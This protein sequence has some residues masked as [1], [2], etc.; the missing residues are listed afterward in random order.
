MADIKYFSEGIIREASRASQQAKS[1]IENLGQN[2]L[3]SEERVVKLRTQL[4]DELFSHHIKNQSE[5]HRVYALTASA[6][7]TAAEAENRMR[8]AASE[9]ERSSAQ[10]EF[11]RAEAYARQAL[12]LAEGT[13]NAALE[14]RAL[15]S[16][17]AITRQNI[18]AE[19][20]YQKTLAASREEL[21]RRAKAEEKRVTDLK[22]KQKELL[23]AYTLFDEKTGELL[24][25]DERAKKL[26][27][28][29]TKLREFIDLASRNKPVD[30]TA[31]V[32]Y[33]NLSA[34]LAREMDSFRIQEILASDA[35][36][37]RLHNQVQ[38]QAGADLYRSTVC[39]VL[40][41]GHRDG[42][43]RPAVAT[44]GRRATQCR[45]TKPDRNTGP[46]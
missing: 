13:D 12:S 19:E 23:D 18:S 22:N 10:E 31:L 1:R 16:L 14:R 27:T 21:A 29:Q 15:E 45:T 28:A 42:I 33:A 32:S 40:E 46:L 6:A 8:K 3:S 35:A 4:D 25:G 26:A 30:A 9:D 5:L 7:E 34:Q 41:Q 36:L 17:S 24:S 20:V 2:V 43:N 37:E 44:C 11:S 39:Q 38:E